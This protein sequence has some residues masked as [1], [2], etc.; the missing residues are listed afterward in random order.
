M[1]NDIINDWTPETK[2]LL[3]GLT[4]AGFTLVSGDNGEDRFKFDGD[5]KKFI[6]NLTACDE[7]HL[8]VKSPKGQTLWLYLV[9]G[10]EPGVIAADYSMG[11]IEGVDELEAVTQAHYNKWENRKQPKT[12][13]AKKYGTPATPAPKMPEAPFDVTG[14]IIAFESGELDQDAVVELFQHLLDTG[15]VHQLQGSY[16]RTCQQLMEAGLVVRK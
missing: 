1:I 15:M 12:T 7:S 5:L 3:K 8:Y 13:R 11:K 2:S 6:D 14:Q 10:N 16:G 4:D 9:L